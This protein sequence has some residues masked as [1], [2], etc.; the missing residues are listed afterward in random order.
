MSRSDLP[1]TNFIKSNY[2]QFKI[3][4]TNWLWYD[5][6]Y[7]GP[8][9]GMIEVDGNKYWAYCIDD[10][11]L[12][13]EASYARVFAVLNMGNDRVEYQEYWHNLFRLCINNNICDIENDVYTKNSYNGAARQFFYVR[14]K[15]DYEE[16]DLS[17][18]SVIG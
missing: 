7:G 14:H 17:K 13:M 11:G 12:L 15:S 3:S 16:I 6:Y 8:L 1:D 9:S 18:C 4:D 2:R 5:E 10:E